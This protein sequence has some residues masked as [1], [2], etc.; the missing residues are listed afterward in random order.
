[1][2][3]IEIKEKRY[4]IFTFLLATLMIALPA[5]GLFYG[6]VTCDYISW[7]SF[8]T[9]DLF[10]IGIFIVLL[11]V[12]SLLCVL[13]IFQL[14]YKLIFPQYIIL[15][16]IG[17]SIN[18]KIV[19]WQDIEDIRYL[20]FKNLANSLF[21]KV[22]LILLLIVSLRLEVLIKLFLAKLLISQQK[23]GNTIS[24]LFSALLT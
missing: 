8:Q 21:N 12:G 23:Y 17:I 10:L 14:L 11:G 1:M 2:K 24:I 22:V 4:N 9:K 18:K 7:Q 5:C 16:E 13:K 3:S 6:I 20:S 19:A 15:S